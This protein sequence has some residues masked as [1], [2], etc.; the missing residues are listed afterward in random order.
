M[1]ELALLISKILF[2]WLVGQTLLSLVFIFYLRQ[3]RK[4]KLLPDEHLPKTALILCLRGAD[5][6][7]PECVS[8][9]LNQ[10]YPN[11]D[12]KIIVDSEQDSAWTIATDVV[13]QQGAS[14]VQVSPLRQPR[15]NCTLKCSSL[16]QAVSDLD[17]S[18]E[19][20]ALVDA[21]TVAHR[22]WLGE[23][24]TPLK[25][26]KVGATTGHRWY[27]PTGNYWGSLVR[28]IWN[29]S[30]VIQMYLYRIPWGGTLAIKTKLLRDTG[31]LEKWGQAFCEDTMTRR[32]L[33]KHGMRVEFVPSLIM[34]NEEE[35]DLPGLARW[36][37][38]QLLCARLYHPWWGAVIGDAFLTILLPTTLLLL[39]LGTLLTGQWQAAAVL[40]GCYGTYLVGLVLIE[41]AIE[42]TIQ[43]AIC[44]PG[45][46]ARKLSLATV[47]K[48][49]VATP[50]TQWVYGYAM[51]LSWRMPQVKWRGIT[52]RVN[53]P[54]K[55]RMLEYLPYQS[56]G[57]PVDSKV[58]L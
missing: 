48:M 52:Y 40:L 15:P 50:L 58:S 13:K 44:K 4:K 22:S 47:A 45:E 14:N 9:L 37:S 29:L 46:S 23:L 30:A 10:D 25:D 56:S 55:I 34:I 7:L 5:P 38:R 39:S 26:P 24:V 54:W 41:V 12:L 57:Q 31:L 19:V 36:L 35:C 11:Y 8:R 1:Y 42:Q 2:G 33:Q 28:Y 20:V 16:H 17:D 27:V 53:G 3:G 43:I 21:D 18:Y 32:A 6:F 49:F 51:I